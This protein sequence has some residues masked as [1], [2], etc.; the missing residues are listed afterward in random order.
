[1]KAFFFLLFFISPFALKAQKNSDKPFNSAIKVVITN[2]LSKQDNYKAIGEAFVDL[3]YYINQKDLE[4][5]TL[6]T[7][8]I[9]NEVEGAREFSQIIY[10]SVKDK[11]ITFTTRYKNKGNIKLS[12]AIDK[13]YEFEP[14]NYGKSYKGKPAFDNIMKVVGKLTATQ[15]IF[16]E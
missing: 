5:G 13:D 11:Q 7:K 3:N 9:Y 8:P 10:A 15:I 12:T 16:S 6:E 4:F 14:L 2:N 1:M